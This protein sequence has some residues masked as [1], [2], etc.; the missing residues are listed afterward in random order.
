MQ[1]RVHADIKYTFSIGFVTFAK[2][3]RLLNRTVCLILRFFVLRTCET[4]SSQ[5]SQT[6]RLC[7]MTPVVNKQFHMFV[8]QRTTHRSCL[9]NIAPVYVGM[10]L[11]P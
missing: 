6:A 9:S 4:L 8:F 5:F 10:L 3:I 1:L 11:M 2:S 7:A